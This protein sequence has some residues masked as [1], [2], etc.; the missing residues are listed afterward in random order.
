MALYHLSWDLA[1]FRIIA[2]DFPVDPPMRIFSHGVA[3]SFLLLVGVSLTLAHS[4][5]INWCGFLRRLAIVGAAAAAVSVATYA[6]EPQQAIFFGILHCIA[7]ASLLALPLVG[8]PFWAA[9][10]AAALAFAAPLFSVSSA[11]DSPTL[12]WLGLSTWTPQTLD[13]RP[14]FPWS[15]FVFLGVGLA[16]LASPRIT[17]PA[18]ATWR[19]VAFPWRA[20]SWAGRHSLAI[21]LVHQPILFG[22]L[23]AWATFTGLDERLSAEGFVATCQSECE[24]GGGQPK[25]CSDACQCVV[26]GLRNADLSIAMRRD[27]LTEPQR[28]GYSKIVRACTATR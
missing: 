12:V 18:L 15:G 20:L 8:A 5:G 6:L 16:R 3:G 9:L 28:E 2:A 21:Y 22:A 17:F 1:Y 10:A 14:L 26:K 11:F 19:P 13:W 24:A 27:D 7:V 4:A 23:F 25:I